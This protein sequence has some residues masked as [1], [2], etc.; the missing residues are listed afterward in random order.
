MSQLTLA[1]LNILLFRCDSE[2]QE[3]GGGCYS[4]PGWETFK[5]AG[6]Q[7]RMHSCTYSRFTLCRHYIAM[8]AMLDK[9]T[10]IHLLSPLKWAAYPSISA[11]RADRRCNICT[12]VSA[13]VAAEHP[14]SPPLKTQCCLVSTGL[15]SVF[16]NVRP[17]NDLGH[18]VCANLRQGDWLIDYVSNRLLHREGPLAQVRPD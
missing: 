17:N 12:A 6:L 16:A 5:Y 8:N 18:P 4:I 11:V 13:S 7:G 2:E 15:I 1:D 10:W 3:D 9:A 14:V